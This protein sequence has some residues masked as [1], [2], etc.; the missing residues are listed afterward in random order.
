MK[1]KFTLVCIIASLLATITSSAQMKQ[2]VLP[3]NWKLSPIGK[4]LPL[5]DLPLNI[6]V[7]PNK[8]YAAITNNGQSTQ[9][10]HLV[11]IDKQTILDYATTPKSWYGLAFSQNNQFLYAS[12]GN[13]N[14]ILKYAIGSNTLII[15]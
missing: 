4:Q 13:D 7:S 10:I 2:T 6:V 5:E 11:D 15:L 9:G 14:W 8:K 1:M 3:N 12:G